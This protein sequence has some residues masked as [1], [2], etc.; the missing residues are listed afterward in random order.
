MPKKNYKK[1]LNTAKNEYR[2]VKAERLRYSYL[3]GNLKK[4]WNIVNTGCKAKSFVSNAV[5]VNSFVTSFINSLEN[6]FAVKNCYS[7]LGY[8]EK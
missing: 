8:C 5:D 7:S 3:H 2:R 1:A 6:N 4:F